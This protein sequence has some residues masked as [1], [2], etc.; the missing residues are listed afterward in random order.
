MIKYT[1]KQIAEQLL[2]LF[3]TIT[4]SITYAEDVLTKTQQINSA[5]EN[6]VDKSERIQL[7]MAGIATHTKDMEKE[8]R[9]WQVEIKDIHNDVVKVVSQITNTETIDNLRRELQSARERLSDFQTKIQQIEENLP[10]FSQ[11][12]NQGL[13]AVQQSALQ[14]EADKKEVSQFAQEIED[15]FH[16]VVQARAEIEQVQKMGANL[17]TMGSEVS[18][19]ALEVRTDK[20]A[21]QRMIVE[22]ENISIAGDNSLWE[23]RK[24]VQSLGQQ[25]DDNLKELGLKLQTQAK[26]Q[27]RLRNWLFCM[28]FGVTILAIAL[29]LNLWQKS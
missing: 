16:Q 8:V 10:I 4:K 13:L 26:S 15:K 18:N 14:I 21:L 9:Q 25:F 20:E 5:V 27:Q 1:D 23:L 3:Q 7:E 12:L 29:I 19:L 17:E 28:T 24:E 22:V 6:Q 2:D 11:N